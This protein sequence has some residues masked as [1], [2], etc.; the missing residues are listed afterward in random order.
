MVSQSTKY[1]DLSTGDVERYRYDYLWEDGHLIEMKESSNKGSNED[2]AY[3]V[4]SRTVY[5]YENARIRLIEVYLA[6]VLKDKYAFEYDRDGVIK[7]YENTSLSSFSHKWETSY[8]NLYAYDAQGRVTKI[9]GVLP[10]MENESTTVSYSNNGATV[11]SSDREIKLTYGGDGR[12]IGE[13]GKYPSGEYR[14]H[15]VDLKYD[16]QGRL[17][18]YTSRYYGSEDA[19]GKGTPHDMRYQLSY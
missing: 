1:Q 3:K 7:S 5:H 16:K 4:Y 8:R 17:I 9:E 6:D 19:Q 12:L 14:Y 10:S 15:R 13:Y 2:T 11:T 18:E